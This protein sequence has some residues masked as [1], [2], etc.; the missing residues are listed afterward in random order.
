MN[1]SWL[2]LKWKKSC[3]SATSRIL[4]YVRKFVICRGVAYSLL[5]LDGRWQARPSSTKFLTHM[6]LEF[7]CFRAEKKCRKFVKSSRVG[8]FSFILWKIALGDGIKLQE[9]MYIS[10]SWKTKCLW[11]IQILTE[12]D[13]QSSLDQEQEKATSSQALHFFIN[14]RLLFL[15]EVHE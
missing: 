10:Q 12:V 13:Q 6:C 1:F 15:E 14:S 8:N 2:K 11:M 3:I 4:S 7:S 5:K 9:R